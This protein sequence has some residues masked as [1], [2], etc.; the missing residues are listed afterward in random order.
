[1]VMIRDRVLSNLESD[2]AIAMEMHRVHESDELM[3]RQARLTL[4]RLAM[5]HEQHDDFDLVWASFVA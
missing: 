4:A 5:A 3:W 2:R 1:M